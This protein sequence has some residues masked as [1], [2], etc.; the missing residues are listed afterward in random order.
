MRW[1]PS[2]STGRE[3][4]ATAD[5]AG[6]ARDQAGA[7]GGFG[8]CHSVLPRGLSGALRWA[9]GPAG[10]RKSTRHGSVSPSQPGRLGTSL[11]AGR[12]SAAR[13]DARDADVA[14][15]IDIAGL[16]DRASWEHRESRR[17]R[18]PSTHR[19]APRRTAT[20]LAPLDAP[21]RTATA[22]DGPRRPARS[23]RRHEGLS[24]FVHLPLV[25]QHYVRSPLRIRKIGLLLADHT[26][27]VVD[28]ARQAEA[29]SRAVASPPG[30]RQHLELAPRADSVRAS[31]TSCLPPGGNGA[32]LS[33]PLKTILPPSASC[34][35]L[36][37][38]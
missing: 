26:E 24:H 4:R 3:V 13:L 32:P 10:S 27:L 9:F 11:D 1:S 25:H 15:G 18:R 20:P 22:R 37:S 33:L 23:F 28:R 17:R 19:N 12:A 31:S 14:A 5:A 29:V 30:G 36:F 38:S 2:D 16:A 8:C 21:Q 35:G 7:W 34:A 6:G